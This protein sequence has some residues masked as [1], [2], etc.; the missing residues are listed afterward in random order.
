MPPSGRQRS[1]PSRRRLIG[2]RYRRSALTG[3]SLVPTTG[4]QA[5]VRHRATAA[6]LGFRVE[7][8]PVPG[9]TRCGRRTLPLGHFR[10][11][12]WAGCSGERPSS[13]APSSASPRR[14][15]V[16]AGSSRLISS[17]PSPWTTSA[18]SSDAGY[19]YAKV[20]GAM[21]ERNTHAMIPSAPEWPAS[22]RSRL[23]SPRRGAICWPLF[24][25]PVV[26]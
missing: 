4:R 6:V 5:E 9:E 1:S 2:N 20:Y 11:S 26:T 15:V 17:T 8:A 14:T 3:S 21:E 19:A 10:M 18:A 23:A 22:Y 13:C 25:S 16:I 24:N 12:F 7:E